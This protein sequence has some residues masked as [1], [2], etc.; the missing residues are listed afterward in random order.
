VAFFVGVSG[1]DG[2][3]EKKKGATASSSRGLHL[4]VEQTPDDTSDVDGT[5]LLAK[6]PPRHPTLP[7]PLA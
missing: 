5:H 6:L 7:Q 1:G 3:T 2:T 4:E